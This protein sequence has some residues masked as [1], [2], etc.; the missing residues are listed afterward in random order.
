MLQRSSRSAYCSYASPSCTACLSV[1]LQ[2]P[3]CHAGR[4]RTAQDEG[5]LPAAI[6]QM[7][8]R[9]RPGLVFDPLMQLARAVRRPCYLV[10]GRT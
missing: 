5:A 8:P 4:T 2:R 3:F 1:E 10:L 9:R 7:T 6:S